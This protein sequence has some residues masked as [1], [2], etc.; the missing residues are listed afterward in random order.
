MGQTPEFLVDQRNYSIER[1]L[2]A[3]APIDKQAGD[4]L[5]RGI[6]FFCRSNGGYS[7]RSNRIYSLA[8]SLKRNYS[9]TSWWDFP[10]VFA[11]L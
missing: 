8:K 6:G 4:F 2:I 9:S 11:E 5:W 1:G 3:L 10:L 7:T